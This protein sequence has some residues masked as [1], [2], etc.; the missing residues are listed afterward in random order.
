MCV[1]RRL[2]AVVR[3]IGRAPLFV[4]RLAWVPVMVCGA[5]LYCGALAAMGRPMWEIKIHWADLVTG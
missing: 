2:Q 4:W 5:V 3:L 1:S